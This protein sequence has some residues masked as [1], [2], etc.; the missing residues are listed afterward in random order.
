MRGVQLN[1]SSGSSLRLPMRNFFLKV[2][3]GKHPSGCIEKNRVE[4]NE[5]DSLTSTPKAISASYGIRSA[6]RA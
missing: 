1:L 6:F 2:F 3:T 5:K 4:S